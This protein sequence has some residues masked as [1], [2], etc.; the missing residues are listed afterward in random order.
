M[1]RMDEAGMELPVCSVKIRFHIDVNRVS[2]GTFGAEKRLVFAVIC[3][4][5]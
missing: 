4:E 1:L 3:G 5:E 2:R